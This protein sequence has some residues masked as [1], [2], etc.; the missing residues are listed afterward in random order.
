MR[1]MKYLTA[2]Y[3]N[4][5]QCIMTHYQCKQNQIWQ[6]LL[7]QPSIELTIWLMEV[8]KLANPSIMTNNLHT[9]LHNSARLMDQNTISQKFLKLGSL[10]ILLIKL[11]KIKSKS[12]RYFKFSN[13]F[14][15][16]SKISKKLSLNM[17]K[18]SSTIYRKEKAN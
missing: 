1:W 12:R 5:N 3:R 2:I 16:C 11:N 13:S 15:L 9:I 14:K 4:K 18:D 7:T 6:R 10:I 8:T 17:S